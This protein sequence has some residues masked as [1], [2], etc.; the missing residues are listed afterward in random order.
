MSGQ[1]KS[2]KGMLGQNM[3]GQVKFGQIKSS[4]DRSGLVKKGFVNLY[5]VMNHEYFLEQEFFG[6]IKYL[7]QAIFWNQL[8][9]G[10]K[11]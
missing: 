6:T 8:Y 4:K 9:F 7:E 2:I 5:Q 3:A 11:I 1:D 10:P